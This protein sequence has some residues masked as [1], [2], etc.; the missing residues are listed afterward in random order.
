M[1]R[2]TTYVTKSK[3][4]VRGLKF[5]EE[6]DSLVSKLHAL[7]VLRRAWV[8]KNAFGR[9]TLLTALFPGDEDGN[10]ADA[11]RKCDKAYDVLRKAPHG[12]KSYYKAQCDANDWEYTL[13]E[14]SSRA[15]RAVARF[16]QILMD[17][18]IY[19]LSQ[20][21]RRSYTSGIYYCVALDKASLDIAVAKHRKG[22][23][24]QARYLKVALEAAAKV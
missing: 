3:A 13:S 12:T 4:V 8:W 17:Q 15:S 2:Q 11:Q 19:F 6:A 10:F 1:A 23:R 7:V 21:S 22:K 24:A 18:K 16:R 5:D 9:D 14:M 20:G